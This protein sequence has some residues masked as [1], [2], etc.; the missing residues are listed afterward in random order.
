MPVTNLSRQGYIRHVPKVVYFVYFVT[1]TKA[2]Q[3][4]LIRVF[5]IRTSIANVDNFSL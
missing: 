3:E 1:L 2:M 5:A 4:V